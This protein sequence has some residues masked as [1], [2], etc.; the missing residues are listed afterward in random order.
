MA[1]DHDVVAIAFKASQVS[2]LPG[3]TVHPAAE[4]EYGAQHSWNVSH[5][6]GLAI[7]RFN[8]RAAAEYFMTA[9]APVLEWQHAPVSVDET[10]RWA[11][12]ISIAQREQ[13]ESALRA[14]RKLDAAPLFPWEEANG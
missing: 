9:I 1:D 14:A 2:R 5:I 7:A 6:S 10:M 8:T 12:R 13:L 3:L 11:Q 4:N